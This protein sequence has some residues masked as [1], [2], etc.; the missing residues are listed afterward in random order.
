MSILTVDNITDVNYSFSTTSATKGTCKAWLNLSAVPGNF[1]ILDSFNIA[2]VGT[3]GYAGQFVI[4]FKNAL[5]NANY[6]PL[7]KTTFAATA[8]GTFYQSPEIDPTTMKLSSFQVQTNYWY[9][10]ATNPF[11]PVNVYISV[12][13]D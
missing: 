13:G 5:S 11:N 9:N 3:T 2:A 4:Y 10:Y 8:A 7:I 12:F 6:V 1:K